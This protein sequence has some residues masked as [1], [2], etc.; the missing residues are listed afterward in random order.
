[1][2][3]VLDIVAHRLKDVLAKRYTWLESPCPKLFVI[4]PADYEIGTGNSQTWLDFDLHF[5]C[6]CGDLQLDGDGFSNPCKTRQLESTKRGVCSC[7]PHVDWDV[8]G[9]P[10]HKDLLKFGT[11]M[12]AILEM[13][14]YGLVIDGVVRVPALKDLQQRKRVMYS[15]VFLMK[16]GIETSHQLWAKGH[17]SLDEIK[18]VTP[19]KEAEFM[20]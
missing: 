6:D 19:L 20:D 5:L 3:G 11:Y 15:M 16:Q 1:P 9:F 2:F 18:P 8:R 13:L 4:L 10:Q 12:M 14:E 17:S 7:V